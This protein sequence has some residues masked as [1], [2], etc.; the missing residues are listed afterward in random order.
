MQF[1]SLRDT[2][3]L[4]MMAHVLCTCKKYMVLYNGI[5]NMAIHIRLMFARLR[6]LQIIKIINKQQTNR[7]QFLILIISWQC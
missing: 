1:I 3:S 2:N 7:K 5:I 4:N 6:A